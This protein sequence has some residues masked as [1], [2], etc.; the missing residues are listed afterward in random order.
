MKKRIARLLIKLQR[1]RSTLELV[2]RK[3]RQQAIITIS[4]ESPRLIDQRLLMEM[5]DY[6]S[7]HKSI[8]KF[9]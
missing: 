8:P 3:E 6:S 2:R 5:G 4:S 1:M 9:L 7:H